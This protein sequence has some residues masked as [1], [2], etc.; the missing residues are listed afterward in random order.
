MLWINHCLISVCTGD[1]IIWKVKG[2]GGGGLKWCQCAIYTPFIPSNYGLLI[3]WTWC[4][5]IYAAHSDRLRLKRFLLKLNIVYR[6]Q[7]ACHAKVG[8]AYLNLTSD[9]VLFNV[10]PYRLYLDY[11]YLYHICPYTSIIT[12]RCWRSWNP[13]LKTR[14]SPA[15]PSRASPP[16]SSG[17]HIYIYF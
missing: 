12:T 15:S 14:V 7:S 6:N 9:G 10:Y 13:Y 11:L 16:G 8:G 17:N 5:Q 1:K 4:R 3:G 2:G